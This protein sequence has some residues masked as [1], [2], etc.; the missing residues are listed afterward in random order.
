IGRR[1]APEKLRQQ[2]QLIVIGEARRSRY[3][4]PR[5]GRHI[6]KLGRSS[7][8]RAAAEIETKPQGAEQI[9]LPPHI[10]RRP[11]DRRIKSLDQL[12]ERCEDFLMRLALRQRPSNQRR[13]GRQTGKPAGIVEKPGGVSPHQLA[14]NGAEMLVQAPPPRRSDLVARL[15]HRPYLGGLSAAYQAG[16]PSVLARQQLDDQR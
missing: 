5:K 9:L 8:H 7:R 14:A 3:G 10:L 11:I 13:R 15:Q 16:V 6:S 12:P 1:V 4:T 2:Q